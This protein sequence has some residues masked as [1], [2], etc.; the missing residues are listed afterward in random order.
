MTN[1]NWTTAIAQKKILTLNKHIKAETHKLIEM[2]RKAR[3]QQLKR[4]TEKRKGS[5]ENREQ[6]MKETR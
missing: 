1:L 5:E 3:P 4:T 2:L 6:I